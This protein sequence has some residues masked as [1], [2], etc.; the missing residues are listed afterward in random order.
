M[1]KTL[2]SI[3]CKGAMT[4][5]GIAMLFTVNSYAQYSDQVKGQLDIIKTYLSD[6]AD[7]TKTHSYL[8]DR[9][10]EGEKDSATLTLRRGW[11]YMLVGVCDNDCTDVDIKVYDEDGDQ[12]AADSDLSDVSA[13]TVEPRFTGEYRV[14][15]E[16]Y[17]CSIDPCY[18]GVGV[19]GK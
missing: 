11:T 6:E 2:K 3:L 14:Q 18:Y 19:F 17:K 16:M 1:K 4:A 8:I 7:V 10:G 13:V 12:V 5:V 15:I 9:I